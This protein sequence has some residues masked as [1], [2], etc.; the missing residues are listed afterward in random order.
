LQLPGA[1]KSAIQA[2]PR[3]HIPFDFG[4]TASISEPVVLVSSLVAI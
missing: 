4:D 1:A 2:L 3:Q